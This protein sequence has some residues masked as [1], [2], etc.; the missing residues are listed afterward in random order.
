MVTLHDFGFSEE[1]IRAIFREQWYLDNNPDIVEAD[2]DPFEHYFHTGFAEERS[3]N[4]LFQPHLYRLLSYVRAAVPA[5]VHYLSQTDPLPR[6]PHPLFSGEWYRRHRSD[7]PAALTDL[8]H[9]IRNGLDHVADPHPL[10]STAWYIERNNLGDLC[11]M[12]PLEHYLSFGWRAGHQP[13]ALVR[14]DTYLMVNKDLGDQIEPLTHYLLF[15]KGHPEYR[16]V[17]PFFDERSYEKQVERA[18]VARSTVF[19]SHFMEIGHKAGLRSSPLPIAPKILDLLLAQQERSRQSLRK[20][21]DPSSAV[22]FAIDW[23]LRAR[24][25]SL[26][27]ADTPLV[28]IIIPTFDHSED[29]IRCLESISDI[30]DITPFEVVVVDDGSSATHADRLKLISGI[31]LCVLEQNLGFA[32]ATTAGVEASRGEFVLLLN[33]DTEVVAGWLDKLVETMRSSTEVG[34]VGSMILR[35]DF[36][37][38]EAGCVVFRDGDARQLGCRELPT[39]WRYQV[40]RDVDYC[41][42]ASLLLR[43][44]LWDEV[45][46]F[47][48]RFAPAY[49]ED[50]DLALTARS[51]GLRV[52]YQPGSVLF[53]NEGSTHG[54]EFTGVKRMQ[55]RNQKLFAEKWADWLS[56]KP[57]NSR[58]WSVEDEWKVRDQSSGSIVIVVDHRV[59]TPTEDSGSVRMT[60]ILKLLRELEHRVVFI[61]ETALLA[62]PASAELADI[63]VEVFGWDYRQQEF[64]SY[65]TS[66]ADRVE[67]V[68]VS[69][70]DVALNVFSAV[71]QSMPMVPFVYDMVDAHGL[72]KR[73]E[74]L[75]TGRDDHR[76]EAVRVETIERRMA[77]ASDIVVTLSQEDEDEIRRLAGIDIR[78]VRLSNIHEPADPGPEFEARNGLL[79][80]GGYEHTPNIDAVVWFVEEI[81]PILEQEIGPVRVTLAGSKPTER[82]LALQ[83]PNVTVPGWIEDLTD[84]YHQSRVA[85]APLRFGAGVK[86]KI[87]EA[88]AFGVPTVSTSVGVDG[89]GLRTGTDI[90]VGN[91]PW[92]FAREVGRIYRD[93]DLWTA[94]RTAGLSTVHENFGWGHSRR[95]IENLVSQASQ[96]RGSRSR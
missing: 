51:R 63:G 28:S 57:T 96:I 31:R 32:G 53:H 54:K 27:F 40:A 69:R 7:H 9:Y 11:G 39:D 20:N 82:V 80:V 14:P 60:N 67:F 59:P 24:N 66:I 50:T 45:D 49:Y 68:M 86:G 94:V 43:R 13:C 90:L 48:P 44:A 92:D 2:T 95:Q 65:L 33:N 84:L 75:V 83:S 85:I 19:L 35:P 6:N 26:K 25:I 38:Q 78:T 55:L 36:L 5:I 47:D 76:R 18:D 34:L 81:L 73:N 52:V 62:Q 21:P 30:P 22:P 72:R 46:G 4:P 15:G 93:R 29:V 61:P 89:M 3:P 41:S 91:S 16:F 8:E 70:P 56:T 23:D 58:S 87:G 71:T 10:F 17:N 1:R 79:F 12:T 77:R 64:R 37:L 74:A 42:G 88:L